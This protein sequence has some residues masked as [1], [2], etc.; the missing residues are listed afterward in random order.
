MGIKSSSRRAYSSLAVVSLA[1]TVNFW[2][3]SLL[4]PLATKYSDELALSPLQTSILVALPVIIGSL[5]RIPLGALTDRYGG[6][7]VLIAACLLAMIPV[8]GL[9]I[10]SSYGVLLTM[11]VLLGVGGASFVAGIPFVSAWFPTKKRGF[12]LGVY[13]MGNAGV[14]V[15]GLLT[16]R[17]AGLIGRDE[18]FIL[19]AI[20]LLFMAIVALPRLS[21]APDWKISKISPRHKFMLAAKQGLTW[22]LAVVYA[23][24]FGAFVA[25][26]V[27]LPILLKTI[28]GLSVT[29]AASRA[30][31]FVLLATLARPVGGWLS[32]HIGGTTI[33]RTVLCGVPI[34]A[35]IVAFQPTLHLY[36]SVAYLSLAVVLGC[37]NGAVFAL[38]GKLAKPDQLGSLSGI[39]GAAGGL[40]GFLPPLIL[41]FTYQHTQTYAPAFLLLSVSSIA[42]LLYVNQRFKAAVYQRRV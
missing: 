7:K 18:T 4:S 36:T 40:G 31:G 23:I 29:D 34:L 37:G 1:L 9:T 22:D 13:A 3:W 42:A 14:A 21:E 17:L 19:V 39:I 25:F 35:T 6:K 12:A 8:L 10:A 33:V 24:T 5:G 20:M 16:P 27:Y 15:G 30:A 32:D 2:A 41:G 28:Y 38:I 26:G 11:A